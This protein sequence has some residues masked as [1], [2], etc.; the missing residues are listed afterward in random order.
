MIINSRKVS[1]GGIIRSVRSVKSVSR[2]SVSRIRELSNEALEKTYATSFSASRSTLVSTIREKRENKSG[3]INPL[4]ASKVLKTFILPKLKEKLQ[5]E[6][7]NSKK[8][9]KKGTNTNK[10]SSCIS[11]SDM[12]Q[13]KLTAS[14]IELRN[15]STQLETTLKTNNKMKQELEFYKQSVETHKMNKKLILNSYDLLPKLQSPE[16]IISKI[17]VKALEYKIALHSVTTQKYLLSSKLS[18]E[19]SENSALKLFKVLRKSHRA[20]DTL[21]HT[22]LGDHLHKIFLTSSKLKIPYHIFSPL[23]MSLKQLGTNKYL[24]FDL[25]ITSTSKNLSEFSSIRQKIFARH[26]EYSYIRTKA[27][28]FKSNVLNK[29]NAMI[30]QLVNN[31]SEIVVVREEVLK[32][33]KALE[34][35]KVEF[36]STRDKFMK[37]QGSSRNAEYICKHCHETYKDEENF[38]WSCKR[39]G[40]DWNGEIYWCC[41]VVNKLSLG[42][43]KSKHEPDIPEEEVQLEPSAK[44]LNEF[45]LCLTC[46]KIGHDFKSCNKDPNSKM[47]TSRSRSQTN[48]KLN[49]VRLRKVK[50]RPFD[51]I[52]KLKLNLSLNAKNN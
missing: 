48:L 41:G 8:I 35:F 11:L 40:S 49:K 20:A 12:L 43:L 26:N 38:N 15:L 33:T 14:K 37:K 36:D 50:S 42:C 17:S 9:L 51:E 28:K 46:K 10:K 13:N 16:H 30:R 24:Y 4:I 5:N 21:N 47:V 1:P 32:K 34:D 18:K 6:I 52:E 29:V 39:H 44:Q 22:V 2:I 25:F 31:T 23:L 45:K 3:Y 7:N 27:K 19:K